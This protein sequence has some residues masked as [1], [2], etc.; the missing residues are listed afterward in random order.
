MFYKGSFDSIKSLS[1]EKMF[2]IKCEGI[3][4]NIKISPDE[5]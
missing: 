1:L 5:K 4:N 2:S 3:I